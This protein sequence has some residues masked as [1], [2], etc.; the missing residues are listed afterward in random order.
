M[1]D[2]LVHIV[3]GAAYAFAGMFSRITTLRH[4]EPHREHAHEMRW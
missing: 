3:I 2:H 1:A 4:H